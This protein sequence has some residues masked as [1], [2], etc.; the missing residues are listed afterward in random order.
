MPKFTIPCCCWLTDGSLSLCHHLLLLPAAKRCEPGLLATPA[1]RPPPSFL[2]C[3]LSLPRWFCS[4]LS[5]SILPL[6]PYSP[7]FPKINLPYTRT[8]FSGPQ[9]YPTH[10]CTASHD[11][12][13]LE[14]LKYWYTKSC[15]N[16]QTC[17]VHSIAGSP[18]EIRAAEIRSDRETEL[19]NNIHCNFNLNLKHASFVY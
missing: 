17:T 14:F 13:H 7:S 2:L 19:F 18:I 5:A 11:T 3:P 10:L 16:F 1:C 9:G 12:H 8:D 6:C 15:L 4:G